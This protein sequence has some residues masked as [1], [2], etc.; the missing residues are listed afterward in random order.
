[1]TENLLPQIAQQRIHDLSQR[2][3]FTSTL[4]PSETVVARQTG[5]T[6]ISQVM[7]SSI[8]HVGFGLM[9][10]GVGGESR[11]LQHAY[12][13]A[14]SNAL[15]RMQQEA[16]LLGANI[17]LDV[18]F[19]GRGFEWSSDLIEFTAVGT[20]FRVQGMQPSPQPILTL[21]EPDELWKLHH[22]GYWPTGIAIGSSFWFEPHADCWGEGSWYSQEL[23]T[24]TRASLGARHMATERFRAFAHHLG[25]QGVVGVRVHR[26]GYDREYESGDVKHISFRLDLV[27]MGT[28]VVRRGNADPPPRPGLVV[29]LRDLPRT[30]FSHG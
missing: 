30:R 2:K 1:M 27:V 15:A 22:A 3:L 7:G 24:H 21:L 8:Y 9:G 6:A 26:K 16:A 23:P 29:D 19:Q 18:K 20:A 25:A 5:L 4:T 14:R 12:E 11:V 28:A 13:S 10:M 17:V